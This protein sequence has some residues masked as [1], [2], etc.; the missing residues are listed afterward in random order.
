MAAK[1]GETQAA[2]AVRGYAW[3]VGLFYA[4]LFLIYGFNVPFLPIWLDWRGLSDREIAVITA[5]PFFL[6]LLV[7]PAAAMAADQAR[8]HRRFII[9]LAWIGLGSVLLLSGAKSFW[10]ILLASLPFALATMT[11]MP[12]T[13]T[14]AVMGVR[15]LAL[16]YGRMRLWGSLTFI[17]VG[18]CGGALVAGAGAWVVVPVLIAG[19]A[20]TVA[21]AHMLPSAPTQ[22]ATATSGARIGW[23]VV[24][25]LLRS[26]LFMAFLLATGAV[27]GAHA[28]F[29]TFG[30]LHWSSQGLSTA[31]SGAL[32]AVAVLAEVVLFAY[33]A[34]V[35]RRVGPVLL[36]LAG[37]AAAVVRWLCM[38]FDP[39]LAVLFALQLLHALTYGATHLGAIHF[40]H[41]AVPPAAAGTA[42]ALYAT[43]AAGLMMGI[44]TLASGPIYA[45][46]AGHA[47]LAPAL[48]AAVGLGAA[49][50]VHRRWRGEELGAASPV[51]LRG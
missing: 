51:G 13:E 49:L 20:A 21:A 43:V 40:I 27:Q 24:G 46:V 38:S 50:F 7:T 15:D 6:R 36:L 3:R 4:A 33:S 8:D 18:L 16:D 12:L 22:A 31:W 11:I 39:P 28:M 41:R 47:Y 17:L 35:V 26:P 9:V 19:A 42:Q 23:G 10:P 37:G 32:W 5:A 2:D 29:Y 25:G 34:A 14:V 1:S 45:A 30:A 44:A 48:L